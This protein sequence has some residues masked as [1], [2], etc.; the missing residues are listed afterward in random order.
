MEIQSRLGIKLFKLTSLTLYLP[1]RAKI[2]LADTV[3]LVFDGIIETVN[4]NSGRYSSVDGSIN[5]T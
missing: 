1:S 4:K 2:V 3:I 5:R